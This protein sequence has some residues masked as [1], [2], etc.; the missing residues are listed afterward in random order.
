MERLPGYVGQILLL[1]VIG[2]LA[3]RGIANFVVNARTLGVSIGWGFLRTNAG[4]EIAQTL[5]PFGPSSTYGDAIVIAALNTLLVVTLAIL[6]STAIALLIAFGRLSTHPLVRSASTAYVEVFR[7]I[8][9]LLQIFFWYF[10][11]IALL[12]DVG[13]SLH[14][15]PALLNNRGLFLPHLTSS[16]WDMPIAEG[17]SVSGGIALLPEL[18]ALTLGLSI[19]N[20]AFLAEI[21]RAGILS[22]PRGQSEAAATV[23]LSGVRAAF[24]IVLP[25]AL[26]VALPASGGQYQTLAKASSLAA[27][28]G[29]PDV[30]QIVGGTVLSQT[31]QALEAMA[32][33]VVLYA[34]INLVI[35]LVV[36]LANRQLTK[37]H[38]R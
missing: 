32:L 33:V 23:G 6:L 5:V 25:Q 2:W 36:N 21:F 27:A 13:D 7:N 19:Y 29:Y 8:P 31:G 1:A 22:V 11:A 24:L 34:A 17:F 18:I 9:M 10:S 20:S 26:R 12:P 28:I 30:M 4:F 38:G 16:G 15:G 35:A 14:I 37:H 3:W